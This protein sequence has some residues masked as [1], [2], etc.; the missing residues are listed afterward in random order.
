M[1]MNKSLK[2]KNKWF[3]W[4]ISL[5]KWRL[6]NL[7]EGTDKMHL[8]AHIISKLE[9]QFAYEYICNQIP[10]RYFKKRKPFLIN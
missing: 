2:S 10:D 3:I 8:M 5:A 6:Q 4:M 7:Q 9:C 1:H